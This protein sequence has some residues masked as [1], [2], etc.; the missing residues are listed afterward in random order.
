[1]LKALKI[2]FGCFLDIE[3][4]NNTTEMG[5][6]VLDKHKKYGPKYGTNELFWGLGIEEETYLQFEKQLH[7]AATIM[8]LNHKPERYS[9]DYYKSYKKTFIDTAFMTTFPD[10]SGFYETPFFLNGY[11]MQKMDFKNEHKTT[12]EKVPKPNPRFK[13]R[14]IFEELQLA[15]PNIFTKGFEEFFTFDGD[16][17]EFITQNFYKVKAKHT[18]AELKKH[19]ADFLQAFN[20][21]LSSS[22][23]FQHYGLLEYPRANPGFAVYYSNPSNIAMFNN[24]T[25]HINITLPSYLGASKDENAPAPL[26]YPEL[27][28]EQHRKTILVYQWLEPLIIANFGTADPFSSQN[29]AFAKGSQR[30]AMS[31][32]I[33]IGSYDTQKMKTGKILTLDV[34]DISG[35][36]T[37]FWW[38]KQ[39]H[40]DSAYTPLFKIGM[41]INFRK[42]YNHGIEL[43]CLDWFPEDRLNE[44]MEFLI[45]GAEAAL[46]HHPASEPIMSE[47]WNSLVLGVLQEGKDHRIPDTSLALYEKILGIELLG[48]DHS[49]ETAYKIILCELKRRY[50]NGAVAKLML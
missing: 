46:L 23:H 50:K 41:D 22:R 47:S 27:F 34:K 19:K 2:I 18:I 32:Y 33:G 3:N 13:G 14:T 15:N 26:L 48:I 39:Y 20:A 17:L 5:P 10:L 35:T 1:M 6:I 24:G 44:L 37:S 45:Y 43:R 12:F 38:Y 11:A 16:T 30:C 25:Y 29:P 9:V 36:E 42:H 21:Y 40:K 31:R 8:R 7:V 4:M 28:I 49:V